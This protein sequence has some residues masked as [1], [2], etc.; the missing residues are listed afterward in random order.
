MIIRE[1]AEPSERWK[2]YS[3]HKSSL[4]VGVGEFQAY[5]VRGVVAQDPFGGT[6]C[7]ASRKATS[8]KR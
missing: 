1:T 6:F 3:A 7:T 5:I 8:F 2:D 4:M